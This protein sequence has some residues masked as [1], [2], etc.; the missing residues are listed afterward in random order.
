[1]NR[2]KKVFLACLSC[3]CVSIT[4]VGMIG[5]DGVMVTPN[6]SGGFLVTPNI[7]TGNEDTA[8]PDGSGEE[9]IHNREDGTACEGVLNEY[10]VCEICWYIS[11]NHTH[12][13]WEKPTGPDCE[14]HYLLVG[15][16]YCEYYEEK[17]VEG[18]GHSFI[19]QREVIEPTCS[20]DG[21]TV[22]EC[23]NGCGATEN[24]DFKVGGHKIVTYN[25]KEPTCGE[26]GWYAYEACK[27]CSYTTY[28]ER[29]ATGQHSYTNYISNNDATCIKE[30]T[31]T[32]RCDNGCGKT[33][34]VTDENTKTEHNWSDGSCVGC[35]KGITY[36]LNSDKASYSVKSIGT[37]E[38]ATLTIPATYNDLPVT[39]IGGSAFMNCSR[40]ASVQI[41]DSV[42]SIGYSAFFGCSNL[43][44]IDIPESITSMGL[45][46][47]TNC[48]SLTS[49][50]I[51][52]IEKWCAISFD[53]GSLDSNP[54]YYAKKLYLNDEL[55]TDLVI[56]NS[57]TE[58]R[59]HAFVNCSSLTS[60]KISDSVTSIGWSAFSGCSSLTEMTLPFVGASKYEKVDTNFSYI[61]GESVTS[62]NGER[63]PTSL[64]K[65]TVTGGTV[66]F[67][68][69]YGCNSLTELTVP[70]IGESKNGTG[71]THFGL[72]FSAGV[73]YKDGREVPASLK[74]VTILGGTVGKDAFFG[75]SN[76]T[77]IEIPDGVTSI[78]ANAFLGCSNLTS[79]EIPDSVTSLGAY[80][81]KGCSS[82]TNIDIPDGVTSIEGAVFMECS[83]LTSM[84][85]PDGVTSIGYRAFEDCSGLTS[86]EIPDSVTSI[87]NGAF[88]GCS[89]LTSVY[90]KGTAEE[91]KSI[92][93][94][95][96]NTCLTNATRYYYSENQPTTEGNYWH[97]DENGEIAVW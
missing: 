25:A 52:D 41:P 96:Y 35:S 78:G 79:I 32:A 3:L 87:G 15:C 36:A 10:G 76:L 4:A 84:D 38:A 77:S 43:T 70:F 56:P 51:T 61:F 75:C 80:A 95:D 88:K 45:F 24:R 82:L 66:D 49:V 1:M 31:K 14:D 18:I 91:W 89:R 58:I 86:I 71:E 72:I 90:Y 47:F 46:A 54:L 5:C 64:K 6:G 21:F 29:A 94:G 55:V 60:V 50:Y 39:E 59:G 28:E 93:I 20:E 34:I 19:V 69:F 30:G 42:T 27:N 9:T 13:L 53:G 62:A 81:F 83:G 63:V 8:S 37:Y 73:Y 74:K 67:C 22:Y 85:I 48:E 16:N 23:V 68:A 26:V 33:D 97:Y 2:L 57:V 12:D 65:V 7:S 17:F 92:E 44:S 40:L 11:K